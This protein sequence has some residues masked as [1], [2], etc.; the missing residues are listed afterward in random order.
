M[1]ISRIDIIGSNGNEGTHYTMEKDQVTL[2]LLELQSYWTY[3]AAQ[4]LAKT[5][6]ECRAYGGA[7]LECAGELKELIDMLTEQPGD[8]KTLY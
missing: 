2:K 5:K 3:R 8:F 6:P 1:K 4:L 7:M